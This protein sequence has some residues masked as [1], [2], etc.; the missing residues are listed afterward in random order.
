M[1]RSCSQRKERS[2]TLQR[3][4]SSG[5]PSVPHT[6]GSPGRLCWTRCVRKI[7]SA[8]RIF[9]GALGFLAL[10]HHVS[11]GIV[12]LAGSPA[13]VLVVNRLFPECRLGLWSCR[14]GA[15]A[16]SSFFVDDNCFDV[17]ISL[18][19]PGSVSV[20]CGGCCFDFMN[21]SCFLSAHS[22]SSVRCVLTYIARTPMVSHVILQLRV[23]DSFD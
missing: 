4:I 7:V 16:W 22:V 15:F 21:A 18:I 10:C 3:V 6:L 17:V 14:C 19:V 11:D 23:L 8:V 20:K 1:R 2:S 5:M 9:E 13:V 12:V